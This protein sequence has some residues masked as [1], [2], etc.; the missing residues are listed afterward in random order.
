MILLKHIPYTYQ[1]IL[2]KAIGKQVRSVI[3]LGCGDGFLMK[4]LSFKENWLITG[5]EIYPDAFIL[6]RK[7]GVYQHIINSSITEIKKSQLNKK[8]DVVFCSQVLEHLSRKEVEQNMNIWEDL[9]KK[10]IVLTTTYGF[11]PYA[12]IEI[13][14]KEKNPYQ[15]HHSG[16]KPDF[17]KKRGYVVRGQGIK[18]IYGQ[19]GMARSL[20]SLMPLWFFLGYIFAPL[21][22]FFPN[23]GTYIVCWKNI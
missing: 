22:Y 13:K 14:I 2:R 11:F 7:S 3:D 19:N 18:F 12:P 20:P 1:W 23:F 5:V 9:A 10:R 4:L 17:F 6:A 15:R 16:W 8:Y 21:P